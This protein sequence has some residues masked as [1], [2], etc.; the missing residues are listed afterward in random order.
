MF[1]ITRKEEKKKERK[2]ERLIWYIINGQRRLAVT[3]IFGTTFRSSNFVLTT[4]F[5][6]FVGTHKD[7]AKKKKKSQT[8]EGEKEWPEKCN[9]LPNTFS[10]HSDFLSFFCEKIVTL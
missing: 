8:Q 3:V 7:V 5:A 10:K 9:Q 4:T 6:P 2:R 1:Q